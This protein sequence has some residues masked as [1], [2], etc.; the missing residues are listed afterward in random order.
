MYGTVA[1]MLVKPGME[2]KLIELS[3]SED[4]LGI[5]GLV[6]TFIYKMD[7]DP[8]EYYLA[9]IFESKDAY[10]KNAD[11]SEQN[12]RYEEYVQCLEGAPEWHDGEIVYSTGQ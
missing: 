2:Q 12:A 7:D 10:T 9:V 1:K 8:N 6:S 4:M 5:P 11:S 3:K